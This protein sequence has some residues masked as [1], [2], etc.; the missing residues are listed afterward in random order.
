MLSSAKSPSPS[1]KDLSTAR[2]IASWKLS[3]SLESKN[4]SFSF[5]GTNCCSFVDFGCFF[6]KNTHWDFTYLPSYLYLD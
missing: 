1:L 5:F 2:F 6:V 4:N 3:I